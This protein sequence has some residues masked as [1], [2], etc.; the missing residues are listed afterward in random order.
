MGIQSQANFNKWGFHFLPSIRFA[1]LYQIC[2]N[3][4]DPGVQN[5]GGPLFKKIRDIA[6]ES[7]NKIP[8]PKPSKAISKGANKGQV[9]QQVNMQRFN[10]RGG[11]CF[12]GECQVLMADGTSRLVKEIRKGDLVMSASGTPARVRCVVNTNCSTES[13]IEVS[14]IGSLIIT[15]Y[16]PILQNGQW[17]FPKDVSSTTQKF[18]QE[19]CS[20]V[21]ESEHSM[22]VEGIACIGWGHGFTE[23]VA[24]HD[25]FGTQRV[26]DDLTIKQ[27][28]EQG[29]IQLQYHSLIRDKLTDLVV[30]LH[31]E[32]LIN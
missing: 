14:Q 30:G 23:P 3:F 16:H 29:Y 12:S 10:Y 17:V 27:G 26:I 18:V 24:Q 21:L 28:W 25:F 9:P 15:P 13:T 22:I 6:E 7:F 5:Y 20:F 4:K 32:I 1:H 11:G 2:N 31:Q 8:P 19:V